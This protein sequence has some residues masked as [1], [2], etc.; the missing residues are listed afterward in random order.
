L[1]DYY[2]EE[3]TYYFAWQAFYM[4]SL[5]FPG[6]SGLIINIIRNYRGDSIDECTLTPFHG[7]LTFFW[8]IA[9]LKFWSREEC[10]LAYSWGTLNS[11]TEGR[12]TF[13]MRHGFEGKPVISKVTG[14]L[15]KYYSP[16]K[17]RAK[18]IVSAL[19]TLVLLSV[20]FFAMILSLN[21]QGY[22]NEEHD[23][24]VWGDG[25][26]H[27]FH[28]PAVAIYAIKGGIFDPVSYRS[29]IPIILHAGGVLLMNLGY[30]KVAQRL[31][32]WE[33]H[34]TSLS[35]KNSLIL[36][37]FFFEA[38]DAYLILFYLAFYEQSVLKV[39]SELIALFHMDTFRRVFVEGIVPFIYQKVFNKE[40]N[41]I[42]DTDVAKKTD[43][44]VKDPALD[45]DINKDEYEQFDDYIESVI[46]FGYVT[47]FASAYPLA[48]FIA[49][50]ASSI[51]Y[52]LDMF[53]LTK[54]CKRPESVLRSDIGIWKSLLKSLVW[55]SAFTNCL[56]F[57][58]SSMQMYQ[59]LPGY[60]SLDETGE[61]NLK[62]GNGWIIV[63]IIFAIERFLIVFGIL[64]D[65]AIPSIPPDVAMKEQRREYIFF[66]QNQ[67][68]RSVLF[69]PNKTMHKTMPQ[70]NPL[71]DR[72]RT[73]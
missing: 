58:F 19:V 61:H 54:T 13:S 47:L 55:L 31:T 46:Q 42:A 44:V 36:K 7:I 2:G 30:S 39:R 33:N 69:N 64:F 16:V 15:T 53:K 48:A 62:A 49:I 22:I 12:G 29:Y 34:D 23:A 4:Y 41:D 32:N 28:F 11:Q 43:E 18:C 26:I 40:K 51:E 5:L 73:F 27:P 50:A 17:R 60:F 45:Q 52:R 1:R 37:R 71:L 72:T 65:F 6:I 38:F 14:K 20:A 3:V 57:S 67:K 21:L 70:A 59:Y 66:Q 24:E 35:H 68:S 9:F 25:L 63:F 10:R 56:I 8:A